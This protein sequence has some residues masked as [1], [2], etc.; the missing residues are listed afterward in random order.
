MWRVCTISMVSLALSS[1]RDV[2]V[3]LSDDVRV[4]LWKNR[5]HA[6]FYFKGFGE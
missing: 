1:L 2:L 3:G 5:T 4:G 6:D